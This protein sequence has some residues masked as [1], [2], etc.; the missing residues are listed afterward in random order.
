MPI[1]GTIGCLTGTVGNA[2][3]DL[4]VGNDLYVA[5]DISVSGSV[6]MPNLRL[7]GDLQVDGGDIKGSDGSI[8]IK[9][10]GDEAL[11]IGDVYTGEG[12][13]VSGNLKV[14][15]VLTGDLTIGS[16]ADGTDRKVTFG[17]AT[18]KTSIGIDDSAD[19]F[20]INTDAN[21]EGPSPI[22]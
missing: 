21:F 17:H 12:L 3:G 6:D 7:T 2:V 16:D 10:T 13:F 8:A 5:G 11:F 15:G 18:L 1:H 14:G 9:L 22:K 20:A 4:T 19:V